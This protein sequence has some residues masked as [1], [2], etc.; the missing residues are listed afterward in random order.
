MWVGPK[1]APP[2]PAPLAANHSGLE[3]LHLGMVGPGPDGAVA[4]GG[5]LK[6]NRRLRTLRMATHHQGFFEV[7]AIGSRRLRRAGRTTT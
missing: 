4:L 6:A 2:P 7:G 1:G 5:A 3:V